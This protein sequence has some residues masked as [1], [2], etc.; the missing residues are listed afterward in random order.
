M[1]TTINMATITAAVEEL[2][3]RTS[4]LADVNIS[5]AEPV[6]DDPDNCPWVGVYRQRQEYNPQ[7]LGKDA[8]HREFVGSV[9]VIAQATHQSGAE[10]E[11]E[12][13]ELVQDV[14]S[15]IFTD[16][17]LRNTVDMVN[18]CNVTYSYDAVN[19]DEEEYENYFQTAIMQ[20]TV[21]ADTT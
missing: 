20:I 12:L 15:A 3:N 13:D 17:E 16:T 11:D 6:N 18:D 21:E 5:R 2:L 8:G 4:S 9:I 7:T 10:C 14:L 19:E 1:T